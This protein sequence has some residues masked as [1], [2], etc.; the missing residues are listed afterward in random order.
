MYDNM[1]YII[2]GTYRDYLLCH[3]VYYYYIVSTHLIFFFYRWR[4]AYTNNF[5]WTGL[6]YFFN[7]DIKIYKIEDD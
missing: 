2:L 6:W 7:K 1:Y 5:N 3:L 4:F